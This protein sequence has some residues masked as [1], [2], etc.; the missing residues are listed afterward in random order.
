M[1]VEEPCHK[2]AIY[3]DKEVLSLAAAG[4]FAE[5][6]RRAV[7][8]RGR[9]DVLL[10]GG[11]TPGRTYQLLGQ[12]P[13]SSS[14]P[15]QAL[16]F[17]WGDERCVPHDSPLSNFAMAR[18]ALLDHVPVSEAQIHPIPYQQSPQESARDYERLLR[19]YFDGR[20][21]RFDLA[22][23]GLGNDGHTA[24]LFPE[25]PVLREPSRWVCEV[26]LP[27]QDLS[28]VTVTAQLINQAALVAFLVAGSGKAA[29]LRQVLEGAHDP[30]RI[31]A[32]L[33][34]PAQGRLLY[35]VDRDAARLLFDRTSCSD[36]SG[37][38]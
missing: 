2:V 6:A 9:F 16:Q 18:S 25:S 13:F 8:A 5:Q 12:E 17:F 26:Y 38:K 27:G 28:R 24:S 35:L 29:M 30:Q 33:I 14:I 23:L 7:K 19:L 10:C 20:P 1:E 3:H 31:P 22:L 32:Q 21:P 11:K 15:W 37:E 4:L 34:D 36:V